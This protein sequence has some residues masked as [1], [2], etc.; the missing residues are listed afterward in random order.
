VRQGT[1]LPLACYLQNPRAERNPASAGSTGRAMQTNRGFTLIELMIVVAILGILL[2]IA[3]PAYQDY[4]TR[5]RVA[6]GI[7]MAASAKMAV[8]DTLHSSGSLPGSGGNS[9][10]GLPAPTRIQGN[11]VSQIEVDDTTGMI[12]ITF[13]GDPQIEGD[14]LTL[15]PR[16]TM[17]SLL[18]SC[19][20]GTLINKWRPSSCRAP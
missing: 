14:T 7:S 15:S 9:A 10:F 3:I 12:E 11:W 5:T 1:L 13:R 8:A 4:T 6:E 18:W 20:G 17:G 16:T 19:R 2:S